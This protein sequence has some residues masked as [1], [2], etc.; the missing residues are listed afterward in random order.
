MNDEVIIK[1]SRALAMLVQIEG[2]VGDSSVS[3]TPRSTPHQTPRASS[4]PTMHT[5]PRTHALSHGT[6]TTTSS[7]GSVGAGG[8]GGS[9]SCSMSVS[10]VMSTTS[11]SSATSNTS[12]T[13]ATNRTHAVV[14]A[15]KICA[16]GGVGALIGQMRRSR[17]D[18]VLQESAAALKHLT[19]VYVCTR[20]LAEWDGVSSIYHDVSDA[21]AVI[22]NIFR[23]SLSA[24]VHRDVAEMLH[25]IALIPDGKQARCRCCLPVH[26]E[27]CVS[28]M[29]PCVL[30]LLL[31]LVYLACSRLRAR[32]VGYANARRCRPSGTPREV[33]TRYAPH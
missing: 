11:V 30:Y 19:R 21:Y 23:R 1:A 13:S 7:A 3:S 6:A 10:S 2:N 14:N 32:H 24:S 8:G 31:Y 27:S 26:I 16:A 25:Y 9:L 4:I 18:R 29:L 33:Q 20:S 22:V 12:T 28:S 5:L 15:V 17:N